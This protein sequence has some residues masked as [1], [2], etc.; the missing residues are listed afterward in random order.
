MNGQTV[1]AERAEFMELV[2]NSYTH[3]YT[4]THTDTPTNPRH[5]L[6]VSLNGKA[7]LADRVELKVLVRKSLK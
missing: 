4:Q 5:I 1:I 3:T 6:E 2:Q 7:M